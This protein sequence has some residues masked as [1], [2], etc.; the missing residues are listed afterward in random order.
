MVNLSANARRASGRLRRTQRDGWGT[1]DEEPGVPVTRAPERRHAA[2]RRVPE[3]P[4]RD[5]RE[6][7]GKPPG[8][9]RGGTV[10]AH[11]LVPDGVRRH[12]RRYR[13]LRSCRTRAVRPGQHDDHAPTSIAIYGGAMGTRSPVGSKPGVLALELAEA[14]GLVGLGAAVLGPGL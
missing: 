8:N 10:E 3:V 13:A 9:Q 4:I 2:G 5:G 1:F 12:H 6:P 14:L 11:E 7:L